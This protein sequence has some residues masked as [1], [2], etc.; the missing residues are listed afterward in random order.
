MPGS[1]KAALTL[2]LIAMLTGQATAQVPA[3]QPGMTMGVPVAMLGDTEVQQELKLDESQ[4]QKSKDLIEATRQKA[5]GNRDRILKLPEAE[6]MPKQKEL[7]RAMNEESMK[8]AGEFLKP[9]QHARL[10]QLE[11]QRRGF[12]AFFD[13]EITKKLGITDEQ[14]E[15]VKAIVAG[16]QI[17]VRALL[18]AAAEGKAGLP[19]VA[20]LRKATLARIIGILTDDQKK[21]WKEMTGEPFEFLPP[22]AAR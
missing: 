2:G 6:R 9:E 14:N 20:V 5:F 1:L 22:N 4:I 10:Y 21:K 12:N 3:V 15:N 18:E 16:E 8:K 11:I 13:P 19:R 7:Q 17:A